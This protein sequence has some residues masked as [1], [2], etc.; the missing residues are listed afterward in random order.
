MIIIV[1]MI[2]IFS[3]CMLHSSYMYGIAGNFSPIIKSQQAAL[4]LLLLLLLLLSKN[5]IVNLV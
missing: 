2:I 5:N 3:W 1:I 4:L